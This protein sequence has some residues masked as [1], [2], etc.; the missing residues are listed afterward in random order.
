METTKKDFNW[1]DYFSFK[2]MISL[3]IIQVIYIIGAIFMT[4]AGLVWLFTGLGLGITGHFL[5]LLLLTVGNIIWRVWCE[6]L[7][8]FFRINQTLNNIEYNTR[9][10]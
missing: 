3:G 1:A 2:A 8:I 4:I 6:L 5:G 9:K 7:I 10:L